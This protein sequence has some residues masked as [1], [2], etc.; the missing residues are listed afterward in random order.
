[1]WKI[2]LSDGT[3]LENLGVNGTYFTTSEEVSEK[4]FAGKLK[5]VKI[6]RTGDAKEN[7][8]APLDEGTHKLLKLASILNFGDGLFRFALV[9]V[10]ASELEKLRTEARITYLAMMTDIELPE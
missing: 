10:S 9:P 8:F 4:T 6:E 2:T 5:N 1:M 7:E 3:I